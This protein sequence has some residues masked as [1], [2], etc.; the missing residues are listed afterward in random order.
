MLKKLYEIEELTN[1]LDGLTMIL[2]N[3]CEC[4]DLP[5]SAYFETLVLANTL[6]GYINEKT[7]EIEVSAQ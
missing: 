2:A 1:T 5:A 4:S 7:K 6:C 3:C